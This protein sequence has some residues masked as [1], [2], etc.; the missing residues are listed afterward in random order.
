MHLLGL[1]LAIHRIYSGLLISS[2][3]TGLVDRQDCMTDKLSILSPRYK[4]A[5]NMFVGLPDKLNV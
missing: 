1:L 2:S 4:F 3:N 5:Q